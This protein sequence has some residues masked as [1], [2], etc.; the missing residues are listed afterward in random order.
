MT[1]MADTPH[2]VGDGESNFGEQIV[3]GV[4][5]QTLLSD[6]AAAHKATTTQC[7]TCL[8]NHFH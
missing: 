7:K 1:G 6:I 8:L 3:L 2:H 5:G 4:L